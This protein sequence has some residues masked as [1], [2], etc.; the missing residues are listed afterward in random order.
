MA[1]FILPQPVIQAISDDEWVLRERYEIEFVVRSKRY[2]LISAAGATTDGLSKPF[3]LRFIPLLG[4]WL[5]NKI[6]PRELPGGWTHDQ[7]YEGEFLPRNIC[8]E[9][10]LY[11]EWKNGLWFLRRRLYYR[12]VRIGGEVVWDNHKPK[13][14]QKAREMNNL[15]CWELGQWT[16]VDLPERGINR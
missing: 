12:A 13:Q 2:K 6:T 11:L 4:F 14:I 15:Y 8:D 9:A 10:F 16:E 7:L 3:W 5:G 1:K